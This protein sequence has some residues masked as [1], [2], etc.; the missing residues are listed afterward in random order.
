[1]IAKISKHFPVLLAV[2]A[3]WRGQAALSRPSQDPYCPAVPFRARGLDRS[4]KLGRPRQVT[5]PISAL[6]MHYLRRSIAQALMRSLRIVK[7]EVLRQ[8]CGDRWYRVIL[9]QIE[10]L[11]LYTAPQ[12]LHKD[13]VEHAPPSIHTDLHP[14]R[15]QP[16][17]KGL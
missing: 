9:V 7:G 13:V 1:M 11:I 17:R 4:A 8:S 10:P 16:R 3:A 6:R 5:D 12:P 2:V 14:C 15:L